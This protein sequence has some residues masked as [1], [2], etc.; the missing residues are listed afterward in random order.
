LAA[1]F[2][3]H[4]LAIQLLGCHT[5]LAKV[6]I[7]PIMVKLKEELIGNQLWRGALGKNN[8]PIKEQERYEYGKMFT[9]HDHDTINVYDADERIKLCKAYLAGIASEKILIGSCG[10]SCHCKDKEQAFDILKPVIFEGFDS[11]TLPK[12][13]HAKKY[14]DTMQLLDHYEREITTLLLAHKDTLETIA[15]ELYDEGTL[16]ATTIEEIIHDTQARPS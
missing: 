6:T 1:H 14:E 13:V 11:D 7:K 3:G 15:L 2:A 8:A 4:A 9:C 5:K 16:E 10:H 12:N